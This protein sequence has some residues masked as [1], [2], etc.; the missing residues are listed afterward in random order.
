MDTLLIVLLCI[1]APFILIAFII[2]LGI[3]L[4]FYLVALFSMIKCLEYLYH[5]IVMASNSIRI[6]F[7]N[8]WKSDTNERI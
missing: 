2:I 1:F 3:S 6:H 8:Y 5:R 7:E 4:W